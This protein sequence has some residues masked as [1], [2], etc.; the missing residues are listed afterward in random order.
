M[1]RAPGSPVCRVRSSPLLPQL[2][3]KINRALA[4]SVFTPAGRKITSL[5][6]FWQKCYK[7]VLD[8]STLP[9]LIAV[10]GPSVAGVVL[11]WLLLPIRIGNVAMMHSQRPCCRPFARDGVA[12]R[13]F[14]G[15][16][17]VQPV[18]KNRD[19]VV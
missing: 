9:P 8:V 11:A 6:Y 14:G 2:Q 18:D 1:G 17:A 3:D 5:K 15:E 13:F 7:I 16:E 4:E 19:S 12:V 10:A